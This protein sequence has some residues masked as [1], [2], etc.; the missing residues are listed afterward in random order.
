M[1]EHFDCVLFQNA[2]DSGME[3]EQTLYFKIP[4]I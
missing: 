3:L 4:I 2:R 1:A